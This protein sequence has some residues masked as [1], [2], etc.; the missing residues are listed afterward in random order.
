MM[1]GLAT[2]REHRESSMPRYP[3]VPAAAPEAFAA[4]P[5]PSAFMVVALSLSPP[6]F[7][8]LR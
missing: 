1:G 6:Y 5:E 4:A 2:R 3:R 7:S 8:T